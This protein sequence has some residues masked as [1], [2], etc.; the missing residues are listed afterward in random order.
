[1]RRELLPLLE[2][3]SPGVV[4]HLGAL[5]DMLAAVPDEAAVSGLGRAQRLAGER[6][7]RLG[8]PSVRLR[9]TGGREV[10]ATFPGGRIVLNPSR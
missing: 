4:D 10:E 1:V 3:L 5:A 8:R 7:R 2:E 9:L 6:A